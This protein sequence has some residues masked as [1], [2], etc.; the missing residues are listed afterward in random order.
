MCVQKY[1]D[2]YMKVTS[3]FNLLLNNNYSQNQV[4]RKLN[5]NDDKQ[6]DVYISADQN[7][8]VSF[9]AA[10][11]KVA[12]ASKNINKGFISVLALLTNAVANA[13][14][15]SLLDAGMTDDEIA[16]NGVFKSFFSQGYVDL[17]NE[18]N[19]VIKKDVK[20]EKIIAIQKEAVVSENND[21]VP[22]ESEIVIP[23]K[24]PG[25][26]CTVDKNTLESDIANGLSTPDIA[27]KYNASIYTIEHLY[28]E[29]N[30]KNPNV[31]QRAKVNDEIIK[32]VKELKQN[33]KS[34]SQI[35]LELNLSLT[36]VNR[37][38]KKQ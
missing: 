37:I 22:V 3:N 28:R 5:L 18:V 7:S 36:T 15:N 21:I 4:S 31:K 17:N 16:N 32:R 33:N 24:R 19:D 34:T 12:Q 10:K 2:L 38:L 35:A 30:V 26:K 6:S 1:K 27:K 23:K 11:K 20:S 9:K 8:L 14:Y 25:R 13:F 29:Y